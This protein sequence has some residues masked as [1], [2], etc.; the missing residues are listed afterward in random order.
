MQHCL[1]LAQKGAGYVAPNPMVGSVIVHK[2]KIIGEGY[3]TKYGAAHAEV[4]AL[5]SVS[6]KDLLKD[7]TL[8]VSLE[9]CNH[10][11]KTPP[12]TKAILEANVP[13]IVV[14]T[15]D[16]N[17]KVSGTGILQLKSKGVE[18]LEDILKVECED[19]NRRYFTFVTKKRPYIILKWAQTGDGYIARDDYSSKWISSE[20]S[21]KLVHN[22][23][24]EEAAIMVGTNTAVYDN[25]SLTVREVEGLNP[26]RVVLDKNLR[27]PKTHN[28]FTDG[29]QTVVFNADE[30]DEQGQTRYIK[31]PFDN[32]LNEILEA[33]Y[34]MDVLSLFVEGGAGLLSSFI[35]E[36]LWDEARVFIS[37]QKFGTGIKAPILSA[38][39]KA[40]ENISSDTLNIFRN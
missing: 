21:R 30:D 16:P 33:L 17:P 39:L 35:A 25:P 31:I 10:Q 8:Y 13:S 3:H 12:C 18:V 27:I 36:N 26:L 20:E 40:T 5:N 37:N 38:D 1:E 7:S 24:S 22:W 9:P 29:D 23:R 2:D 19:L 4:E 32:T 15:R 14:G 6:E 11:G 34:S 28:I